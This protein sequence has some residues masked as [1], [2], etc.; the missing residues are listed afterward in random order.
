MQGKAEDPILT[1]PGAPVPR[2]GQLNRF[3]EPSVDCIKRVVARAAK[4]TI[5]QMDSQDRRRFLAWPRQVAMYLARELT[6]NSYPMLGRLFG[7][8]DHTTVLFAHAKVKHLVETSELVAGQ[9]VA[10]TSAIIAVCGP[11]TG[12]LSPALLPAESSFD[13]TPL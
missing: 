2:P 7:D 6:S 4:I 10:L 3:G 8:R 1:I 5:D 11:T 12:K 9:V 13:S